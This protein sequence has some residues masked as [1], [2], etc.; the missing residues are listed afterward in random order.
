M[1]LRNTLSKF[2][3]ACLVFCFHSSI[4]IANATIDP[5][6]HKIALKITNSIDSEGNVDSEEETHVQYFTSI[7]TALNRDGDNGQWYPESISWTKKSNTDVKLLLGVITDS[8]ADV[9]L[10]FQSS[11]NGTFTFDYYDSDNGVQLKKVS[12]GSGTFTFNAYENSI[13]P[14]DYYFTDSF[15]KLSVSTNLWPL[16]IHD[17]VTTTVKEGNF[18]IS[19]TN[20]RWQIDCS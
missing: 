12:S 11:E 8:Y 9:S 6:G 18:F 14:F 15:D 4:A 13:I 7:T 20:Y 5:T 19:G 10:Y 16:R 1:H 17:G 2:I 3:F